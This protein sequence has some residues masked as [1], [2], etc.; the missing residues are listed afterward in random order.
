MPPFAKIF[1]T[2]WLLIKVSI[3]FG[4]TDSMAVTS[5]AY[6]PALQKVY[7]T[8]DK[9]IYTV[10][11]QLWFAAYLL[12]NHSRIKD[13]TD[14]LTV[15][16][17]DPVSAQMVAV[18][19]FPVRDG[20]ASGNI[21]LPDSLVAGEY[22]MVAYTNI[23]DEHQHPLGTGFRPL[24]IY[25]KTGEKSF[26]TTLKIS[27]A[28]S[29]ADKIAVLHEMASDA[30]EVIFKEVRVK[31][32][33]TGEKTR[34]LQ[35]DQYGKGVVYLNRKDVKEGNRFLSFTTIYNGD[36]V[37]NRIRIPGES[38]ARTGFS[39]AFYPEGGFL[40]AGYENR[41]FWEATDSNKVIA[42][43][44]LLMEDGQVIDTIHTEANGSSRFYMQA[45]AGRHYTVAPVHNPSGLQFPLPEVRTGGIRFEIPDLVVNDSLIIDLWSKEKK[46][47]K[48]I[49]VD[50]AGLPTVHELEINLYK[51]LT[52]LLEG[53][54]RGLCKIFIADE[55]NNLLAKSYFFAHYKGKNQLHLATNQ[56][57]YKTR[58]SIRVSIKVTDEK[59]AA[60]NALA[61]VSCALLSRT[62]FT[63]LKSIETDYSLGAVGY[64]EAAFLKRQNILDSSALLEHIIRMKNVDDDT[65]L[66][67]GND[68]SQRLT[69][70]SVRLQLARFG[71]RER[72]S[73]EL[74]LFRET[75]FSVIK[76]NDQGLSPISN[77]ELLVND[78]RKIFIKGM[79]EKNGDYY[80][81][82]DDSLVSA[83]AHIRVP[84]YQPVRRELTPDLQA[85]LKT[86]RNEK[87][88]STLATVVVRSRTNYGALGRANACGDYVC[89][90]NILNCPNHTIPYK[91]PVKGERYRSFGVDLVYQGCDY[92]NS[93]YLPATSLIYLPRT[94][95]GMDSTLLKQQFPEYL[96]TLYWQP[97]K[98][99]RKE[100]ENTVTF[101]T[102][103][104]TGVYLLTVQGFA[105][106]GQPFYGEKTIRVTD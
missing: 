16:I 103:D 20:F 96:S 6:S 29:T 30:Y 106:N 65:L 79:G 101:H 84:F 7:L 8:T 31:Y 24:S 105:D 48:L 40:T 68:L 37:K 75:R 90:F 89:Q 18:K 73:M 21:L 36:T 22:C 32:Q 82:A 98:A 51:R 25:A 27:D 45:K 69:K 77:S 34:T 35:P 102:S 46:T 57:V 55:K 72:K 61:T 83:Y 64:H 42:S 97:F 86:D 74:V 10:N 26:T 17:Y 56:E 88:S 60:L 43:S 95:L 99:L 87:F 92:E 52:I 28:L 94:F 76:T 63:N 41:L 71:K 81:Q 14:V 49:I 19:K 67:K 38:S 54:D 4:Q 12:E 2:T 93:M 59:G 5:D 15:G 33:L 62:N 100:Q 80:V 85:L 50:V 70:P 1:L 47:V 44:A 104:Q 3:L 58:D 11:E 53:F 13:T 39:A 23:L 78:G 91:W 9:V 66:L